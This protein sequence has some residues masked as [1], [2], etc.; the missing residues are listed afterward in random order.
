MSILFCRLPLRRTSCHS[1]LNSLDAYAKGPKIN[2]ATGAP[3]AST[4]WDVFELIEADQMR[5]WSRPD[6]VGPRLKAVIGPEGASI[7][8]SQIFVLDAELWHRGTRS[9]A[10]CRCRGAYPR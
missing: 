6:R 2:R 10:R 8:I 5:L 7:D 1:C 9:A 3:F 4:K